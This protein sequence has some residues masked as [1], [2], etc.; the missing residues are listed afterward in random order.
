MQTKSTKIQDV[1]RRALGRLGTWYR[2]HPMRFTAGLSVALCL[3]LEI[4]GRHSLVDTL[5][6]V[7]GH[8][9]HFLANAAI[10][11][12]T[13]SVSFLF[14]RRR[15][16]LPLL[17]ILW[18]ILGFINCVVRFFRATPLGASD[19]LLIPSGFSIIGLYLDMWLIVLLVLAVAAGL[20]CLVRAFLKS[21][22]TPPDY[23]RATAFVLVSAA[24]AA[25]LYGGTVWGR[26]EERAEAYRN[27]ID[28]YDH[29]GF[30]YCFWTGALDR[31][32]GE[33]DTYGP[34]A[35]EAL[36]ED[37]D[38]AAPAPAAE[39]LPD[40]VM[41]QLESFFDVDYLGDVT[42]DQDP[43]PVFR[44]LKEDYASGFLT[45][46]SVGAGT[47]NTE[48]EVLSGM[49][50]DFFGMGEYPYMTVLQEQTCE[51]VA[52]DL[53]KLGYEA[54]AFHNNTGA[55]Y[56]R[57]VVFSQLGFDTYTSLEFMNDVTYN[58][59]GWARDEAL[60]APM[61]QALDQTGGPAFLFAITV[62]GHGKY[63]R[64]V[65]SVDLEKQTIT[66]A[67]D[68]EDEDALAYYLGQLKETDDFIGRLVRML[69]DR[70][71]PAV[72]VLY[73]DHLPNFDI[74][75][76][77]LKNGDI[78]QTE[79]VIWDNMGLPVEDRDLDAYQLSAYVLGRL[80][81]SGGV[82]SRYHQQRQDQTNY[83]E[84][85]ELLEY[86]MLYGEKYCFGGAEKDPYAPSTL[87]MGLTP[88]TVED[89]SWADGALTVSGEGYT[90]WS[91]VTVDGDELDTVLSADKTALTA[92]LDEPPE[93]GE[94]LTVRQRAENLTGILAESG[95]YVWPG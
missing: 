32:I 3:A 16:L 62:Q 47:A 48:F 17:S 89:A 49:S 23:R 90:P 80:G 54:H 82:L 35:V 39:T 68:E 58:P 14:R 72:L 4:L 29:Y 51:T 57:N 86:D 59:I 76:E 26:E 37:L 83:E 25:A 44:S 33:P 19:V 28:A 1:L 43:I 85:L 91:R 24:L 60:L 22:K 2:L 95:E 64:G 18:L 66:W 40:I 75:S 21:E 55:F 74:G 12:A 30:V 36:V 53:K 9:V 73:G 77:E 10:I 67:D 20:V 92:E 50:L 69:S 93:P 38:P 31:G 78:F 94:V 45:V 42:Y 88:L 87:R 81:L 13:L 5:G 41:V 52:A 65:D 8:P 34:E 27:L 46:P 71:R 79:Y 61:E 84:G 70:D 15:F 63:Q 7:V 6:F 56:S 11:L